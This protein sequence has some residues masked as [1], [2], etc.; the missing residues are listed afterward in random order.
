MTFIQTIILNCISALLTVYSTYLFFNCFLSIRCNHFIRNTILIFS[1]ILCIA[2]LTWAEIK[3]LN[4]LILFV[5]V[6]SISL[7]FKSKWYNYLFL[8]L[9]FV[10]ISVFIESVAG[11][12]LSIIFSIDMAQSNQGVFYVLGL[13]LSKFIT[14]LS[15][16]LI[17]LKRRK[18]L[19]KALPQNILLVL[20]IPISTIA[21]LILQYRFYM[22]IPSSNQNLSTTVLICY[23]L[24]IF[25]NLLVFYII[26]CLYTDFEKDAKL[27]TASELIQKQ[28]EQYSQLL[29]HKNDLLRIRHDQKNFILGISSAIKSGQYQDAL[30]VLKKE[31]DVVNQ[32][33][34]LY[35][36][37]ANVI[38]TVVASKKDEAAKN[39]IEIDFEYR[40][41]KP[42]EISPVDLAII[43]GNILDNAIEATA[44]VTAVTRRITIYVGM[45][46]DSIIINVKNPTCETVDTTKLSTSK[47][48]RWQHGFGII[49]AQRLT[50]KYRGDITFDCKNYE[51]Q[52]VVLLKNEPLQIK[53]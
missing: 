6:I 13:F 35:H 19:Y 17:R 11:A 47:I 36:N 46:D 14:Y 31:Y 45:P 51:F 26:D 8:S 5:I 42:I 27:Q 39:N 15:I 10:A 52:T 7:L 50:S 37:K 38:F 43:L 4:L 16:I 9:I 3:I 30:D 49:S 34:Y 44:K 12:S 1:T 2:T 24:L 48:D 53:Q 22:Q 41:L 25:S 18:L 21:V 20:L 29:E 23:S 33:T 28:S 40:D 32:D